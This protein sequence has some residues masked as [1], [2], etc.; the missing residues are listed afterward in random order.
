MPDWNTRELQDLK[1]FI[2]LFVECM[3]KKDLR[4]LESIFDSNAILHR[5]MKNHLG[6]TEIADWYKNMWKHKGFSNSIFI[7]KDATSGIFPDNTAKVILWFEIHVPD[8]D[9]N[10]IKENQIHIETLDLIKQ[11]NEW[12]IQKCLGL[13]YDPIEHDKAF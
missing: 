2:L 7:L 11:E 3:N 12:K 4:I 10:G 9:K 8:F 6:F 1:E 5:E 13:G